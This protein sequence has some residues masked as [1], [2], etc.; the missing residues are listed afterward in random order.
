MTETAY[1]E[2]VYP[3]YPYHQSHPENLATVARL[4]GLRPPAADACTI[5]ELGC[6]GGGNLLPMAEM[7]PQ[8]RFVGIDLS[9]RQ[10]ETGQAAVRTLGLH[11]LSLRTESIADVTPDRG[12]FDYILC[13]GVYSWVPDE[14]QDRILAVCRENL[15]PT[16]VA[17]VSYNT[18]PGWHM[19]GMLR[20]IMCFHAARYTQPEEQVREARMLLDFLAEAG[21]G[22]NS[23]HSLLLRQE[24]EMLRQQSDAYL[25]HEHLEEHNSP[26]YFFEFAHKVKAAGLQYLGDATVQTMFPHGYPPKILQT[27][28]RLARDLIQLEQYLDFVRNRMFRMSLLCHADVPLV[29]TI[30]VDLLQE[31]HLS[32][33]AV[34]DPGGAEGKQLPAGAA[35]FKLHTGGT[36][37]TGDSVA[38]AAMAALG[39]A[40]PE[41]VPFDRLAEGLVAAGVTEATPEGRHRLAAVLMSLL[42]GSAV[43]AS[44]GPARCVA[45]VSGSPAVTP[46]ARYLAAKEGWLPTRRHTVFRTDEFGRRA[47]PLLNGQRTRDGVV[48]ELVREFEAGRLP[49]KQDGVPVRDAN[50]ARPIFAAA[51]T[52]CLGHLL[53]AGAL[54]G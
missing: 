44:V 38:T 6:A 40:W 29:R 31:M 50:R 35:V 41:S 8:G 14:V 54:V 12:R 47:V 5:L 51:L 25:Y 10:V 7:F 9:A 24:T 19:R 45:Q 20:E 46:L 53:R 26:C 37:T 27:L 23:P 3:S 39:R 22:E 16:G 49:V 52:N 34:P 32:A 30:D 43:S 1:D 13:H 33:A 4:F 2:V 42:A 28:N 21:A 48:E 36:V 15:A 11:N 18:Y 17:Y